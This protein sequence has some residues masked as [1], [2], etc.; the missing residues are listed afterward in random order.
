MSE[1]EGHRSRGRGRADPITRGENESGSG[2]RCEPGSHWSVQVFSSSD[3]STDQEGDEVCRR[4]NEIHLLSRAPAPAVVRRDARSTERVIAVGFFGLIDK[5][6]VGRRKL[7]VIIP[8]LS[9][10]RE[11]RI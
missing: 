5:S 8:R 1:S 9:C 3:W 11:W 10:Y 7:L 2:V 6:T 4:I